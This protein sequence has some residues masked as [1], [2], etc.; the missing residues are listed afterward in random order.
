M[1]AY[2]ESADGSESVLAS[3]GIAS[4][5]ASNVRYTIV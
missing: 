5:E 2:N 3:K 1:V 4:H